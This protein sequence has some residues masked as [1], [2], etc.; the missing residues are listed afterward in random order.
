MHA[1]SCDNMAISLNILI[2]YLKV[3][4]SYSDADS[5]SH[6]QLLDDLFKIDGVDGAR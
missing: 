1:L 6:R 5:G 2:F 3:A 4:R